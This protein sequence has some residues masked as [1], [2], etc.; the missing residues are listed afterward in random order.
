MVKVSYGGG[1]GSYYI[2]YVRWNLD[3]P[4]ACIVPHFA[5]NTLRFSLDVPYLCLTVI[6]A[7]ENGG[8]I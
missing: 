2:Q 3:V 8:G 4:T 1:V 7:F 5:R 6:E